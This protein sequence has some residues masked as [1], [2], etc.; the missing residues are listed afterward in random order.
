MYLMGLVQLAWDG[1][2][3]VLGVR[4]GADFVLGSS[5]S[6]AAAPVLAADSGGVITV[7][8]PRLRELCQQSLDCAK[9]YLAGYR[10][11]CWEPQQ[12]LREVAELDGFETR[13][14]SLLGAA[15]AQPAAGPLIQA[16]ARGLVRGLA[17]ELAT[18]SPEWLGAFGAER[19]L[20]GSTPDWLFEEEMDW[21]YLARVHHHLILNVLIFALCHECAH[22]LL[23]HLTTTAEHTVAQ[24]RNHEIDADAYALNACAASGSVDL[25]A[26]FRIFRLMH[27]ADPLPAEVPFTHPHSTDRLLLLGTA[28]QKALSVKAPVLRDEVNGLL[29]ALQTRYGSMDDHDGFPAELYLASDLDGAVIEARVHEQ[30]VAKP[31]DGA[32]DRNP[33][34]WVDAQAAF[35]DPASTS[36]LTSA[37]VL[38]LLIE[39][40]TTDHQMNET[41]PRMTKFV[42]QRVRTPPSWRMQWPHGRLELRE[43]Q[44][45]KALESDNHAGHFTAHHADFTADKLLKRHVLWNLPVDALLGTVTQQDVQV[46]TDVP[47][48]LEFAKW[49]DEY[50][51]PDDAVRLRIS[52]VELDAVAVP[53]TTASELIKSLIDIG[54]ADEESLDFK[55]A[56]T[57]AATYWEGTGNPVAFLHEALCRKAIDERRWF[58]AFEHAFIESCLFPDARNEGVVIAGACYVIRAFAPPSDDALKVIDQIQLYNSPPGKFGRHRLRRTLHECL[59]ILDGI[60][61]NTIRLSVQ[62]LRAEVLT[63]LFRLGDRQ[64]GEIARQVFDW[65]I[66]GFPWFIPA[67]AQACHLALEQGRIEEARHYIRLGED[68]DAIHEQVRQARQHLL[69]RIQGPVRYSPPRRAS[70]PWTFR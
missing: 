44:N 46:P 37:D 70:A 52:A 26:T 51:R 50:D 30:F 57:V 27:N 36:V 9:Q 15:A 18:P 65:I 48:L 67:Y 32:L 7:G 11:A 42:S 16:A 10:M 19:T 60:T 24:S 64:A 38:I 14:L 6:S 22:M 56:A 45:F 21:P 31:P 55:M 1:L 62:Q 63:D 3:E 41:G 12:P 17:G 34:L 2:T 33:K 35:I 39:W 58:D 61:S 69:R 28:M 53:A 40:G 66:A 13:L 23:G 49:C 4:A 47:A 43:L 8:M 29:G 20:G 5:E 25:R 68:R 54:S 59:A